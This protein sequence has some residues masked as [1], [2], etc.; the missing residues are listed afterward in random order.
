MVSRSVIHHNPITS[1][2]TYHNREHDNIPFPWYQGQL[3]TTILSR[4]CQDFDTNCVHYLCSD[5]QN[6]RTRVSFQGAPFN[7]KNTMVQFYHTSQFH[8]RSGMQSGLRSNT[9]ADMIPTW[10]KSRMDLQSFKFYRAAQLALIHTGAQTECCASALVSMTTGKSVLDLPRPIFYMFF[11]ILS[12]FQCPY[13]QVQVV[14]RYTP[15]LK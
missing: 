11:Q 6:S 15:L 14:W 8:S 4:H 12:C 1:L 5:S 3:Y 10:V 2:Y 9:L 13:I 7:M